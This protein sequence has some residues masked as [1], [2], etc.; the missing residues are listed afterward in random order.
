[1]TDPT[2]PAAM[3]DDTLSEQINLLWALLNRFD[4]A[5]PVSHPENR[6]VDRDAH[7][8]LSVAELSTLR[9][10]FMT[11][12]FVQRLRA[13]PG[14]VVPDIDAIA[15][16]ICVGDFVAIGGTATCPCGILRSKCEASIHRATAARIVAALTP[17]K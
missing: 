3:S 7:I 17:E 2:P 4:D 14:G 8:F 1:M 9:D 13:A 12:Q 5:Q 6:D 10:A 11:L 15:E 16:I